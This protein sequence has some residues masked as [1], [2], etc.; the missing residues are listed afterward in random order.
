MKKVLR[1]FLVFF[2]QRLL[3]LLGDAQ[4]RELLSRFKSCGED[5]VLYFPVSIQGPEH[6]TLGDNVAVSAFVQMFGQGGI[7]IGNRVMI[8]SHTAITSL[9]H[10]YCQERMQGTLI[11]KPVV[12]EDDV[13]I[14]AHCVIMPGVVI[15]AGSVLGAGSIV[16]KDVEPYS[17]VV[18]APARALKWREVRGAKG[19]VLGQQI[20][21]VV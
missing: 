15:G 1:R 11:K 3:R 21:K 14:G 6:I 2:A 17:I 13:W 9:T 12:I 18:G 4:T 20:A 16:T 5:V 19:E 7:L 8:G 10:D